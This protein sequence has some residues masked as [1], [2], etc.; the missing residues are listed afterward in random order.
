MN[1]EE[2]YTNEIIIPLLQNMGFSDVRNNH[3]IDE[4]GK[5]ILFSDYNRFGI[6][7][8]HAAQV[9]FKN[10][11]GKNQG[12]MGDI[13]EH[14]KRAFNMPF[15]D[16]I[17]KENVYINYFYVMISEE[18]KQSAIEIILRD[19]NIN[20]YKNRLHFFDGNK[21]KELRQ[22]NLVN[23]EGKLNS[24]L[25]ELDFNEHYLDIIK[26]DLEQND[27][28]AVSPLIILKRSVI[29]MILCE[30]YLDKYIDFNKLHDLYHILCMLN[31]NF[32]QLPFYGWENKNNV[33]FTL[34]LIIKG[35]NLHRI[36]RQAVNQILLK[37]HK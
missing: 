13:I 15:P 27:V 25:K 26:I 28:R 31:S 35:K 4:F 10:I 1:D 33:K 23:V 3:G 34:D 2:E 12:D 32:A 36:I 17:S 20:Q 37:L 5:D 21:I 16:I 30:D 9:K 24:L 29:E 11:N 18:Y 8:Y 7:Q 6:K 19:L 22:V 14:I